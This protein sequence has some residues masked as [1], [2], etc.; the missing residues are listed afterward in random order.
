MCNASGTWVDAAACVDQTCVSGSCSG[1]C[2][3][4][5]TT[6]IGQTPQ[7]CNASGQWQAG[8]ACSGATPACTL[9]GCVAGP[10]SCGTSGNGLTNCGASS[11][12]CC[13]S[14]EVS[15]GTVY[16]T[17][18]NGGGGPM[19]EADPASISNFRLDKYDVTVGR[20]R[21]FVAAWKGGYTPPTG[22][23][24]HKHLNGGQGLVNAGSDAGTT[25]EPGWIATDS[26]N[27]GPSDTNLQCGSITGYH[28]WTWTSTPGANEN[29]PINC[30][31]WYEAYAFCIWDGGFLPS[32]AEWEYVNAGGNQQREYPWGTAAPGT[33]N[34]YA[35]YGCLYPS[36]S[37]TCSATD[38]SNIAPVGTATLGASRW[39]QLDIEGNMDVWVLDWSTSYVDPC[40]DCAYTTPLSSKVYRGNPFE[41]Y[42]SYLSAPGQ[43]QGYSAVT[44]VFPIGF[45]C[46]RTP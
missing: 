44:R 22:S 32:D 27:I 1:F 14:L 37:G 23:G 13:A 15:G 42:A 4:G 19:G 40:V 34:Q 11:E 12:S 36:G 9:T 18:V 45:R 31:N 3:P 39:G 30:A 33:A 41:L 2:A 43:R 26:G 35:I 16:R 29:L 25:Y 38:A 7:S 20:F 28:A 21:Q 46:A 8:T 6:C 5:Q 10:L 24:K 17:Y